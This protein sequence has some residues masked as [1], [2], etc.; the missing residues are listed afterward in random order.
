MSTCSSW[1]SVG[2][3]GHH[4]CCK[5]CR[6]VLII[7]EIKNI[8]TQNV[9]QKEENLVEVDQLPMRWDKSKEIIVSEFL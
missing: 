9:G 5:A 1:W 2:R 8:P 7:I 4:C 6:R 3:S